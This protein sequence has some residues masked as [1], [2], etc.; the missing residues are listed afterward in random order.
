LDL[1]QDVDAISVLLD[2]PRNT[3]DLSLNA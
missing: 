2:H 1:S 3:A